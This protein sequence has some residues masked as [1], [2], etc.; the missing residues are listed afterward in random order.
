MSDGSVTVPVK[1]VAAALPRL[2]ATL[3]RYVCGACVALFVA[4]LIT[5]L[6]QIVFRYVL[7]SPLVWTEELARY[8][9]IWACYL[10]APVALRRGNHIVITVVVD[11]LPPQ[12]ARPVTFG[13]EAVALFFLLQLAIQGAV[14]A[15]RSHTVMAITLPIPWS[16]IYLAAPVSAVLMILEMTEA[17]WIA[18]GRQAWEARP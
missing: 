12:V 1:G 18:R 11:R 5:M 15:L 8:L 9:Y 4:I 14:L 10:G 16:V 7:S 17:V 13:I 2:T 6:L 3:H